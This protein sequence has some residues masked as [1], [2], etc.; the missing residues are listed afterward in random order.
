MKRFVQVAPPSRG[1]GRWTTHVVIALLA[2]VPAFAATASCPTATTTTLNPTTPPFNNDTTLVTIPG[3]GTTGPTA[4]TT[5]NALANL[6]TYTGGVANFASGGCLATDISFNNFRVTSSATTMSV[7]PNGGITPTDGAKTEANFYGAFSS[8]T[9]GASAIFAGV[10]GTGGNNS[11]TNQNDGTNNF[12][13]NGTTNITFN[14]LYTMDATA[15][16]T[17]TGSSIAMRY[18]NFTTDPNNSVT[19]YLC[20]NYTATTVQTTAFT[21]CASVGGTLVSYTQSLAG[22]FSNDNSL[23]TIASNNLSSFNFTKAYVDIALTLNGT[24]TGVGSLPNSYL[25]DLG[26]G[27]TETPEPST[28]GMM[29]LALL[30]GGLMF[31][32]KRQ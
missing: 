7:A 4:A 6:N 32:R 29:G 3:V 15:G 26:V 12:F 27:I 25:F 31:R 8:A 19:V 5:D 13:N 16:K 10:R 1:I 11:D 28:F 14:F 21:S 20:G 22:L 23:N 18:Y 24:N 2:C 17:L 9:N 30:G